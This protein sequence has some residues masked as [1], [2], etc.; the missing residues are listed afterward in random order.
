MVCRRPR[1]NAV[2]GSLSFSNAQVWQNNLG[3][4]HRASTL[5]GHKLE[6]NLCSP[7]K[8]KPS[9]AI[10]I[11]L[12][13]VFHSLSTLPSSWVGRNSPDLEEYSED[14]RIR[15]SAATKLPDSYQHL[16]HL[17]IGLKRFLETANEENNIQRVTITCQEPQGSWEEMRKK[18]STFQD[19]TM[20]SSQA[21]L[22]PAGSLGCQQNACDVSS[23]CKTLKDIPRKSSL[24]VLKGKSL[25]ILML[26]GSLLD[27]TNIKLKCWVCLFPTRN[28]SIKSSLSKRLL[29]S[30]VSD[31]CLFWCRW[32]TAKWGCMHWKPSPNPRTNFSPQ[33]HFSVPWTLHKFIFHFAYI[34]LCAL[35]TYVAL[36][37]LCDSLSCLERLSSASCDWRK[38]WVG[39]L[40]VSVEK[41]SPAGWASA[42]HSSPTLPWP[43]LVK[44]NEKSSS[45]IQAFLE[46]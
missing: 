19:T 24:Q 34:C 14:L 10:I 11:P 38:L 42:I 8:L 13:F 2:F 7:A 39:R 3:W 41:H 26:T 31:P 16:D 43:Q 29:L 46:G 35:T 33:M 5:W 27:L 23:A 6:L 44:I 25:T 17:C 12:T 15:F 22:D 21:Q 9:S 18:P 20:A 45:L 1:L 30:I 37:D 40:W 36:E 32:G 28:K 4:E